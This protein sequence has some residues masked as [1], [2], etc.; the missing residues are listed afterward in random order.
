MNTQDL[1]SR[2]CRAAEDGMCV[3]P[4]K[5]SP[6]RS[7]PGKHTKTPRVEWKKY[8]T[9]D[10]EQVVKL[11][12]EGA[13]HFGID[14][15][16]SGIWVVDIDD[17]AS[18][19]R[20]P[21]RL[22]RVQGTISG[23][24]HYIYRRAGF[25]QRNTT[26]APTAGVDIRANGGFIVWYGIGDMVEDDIQPW[27][28]DE[29]ILQNGNKGGTKPTWEPRVVHE[30][31]RDNDLIS[32][33]GTFIRRYP[34]ATLDLVVPYAVGHSS[35]YHHP[36]LSRDECV[37]CATSSMRWRRED[38]TE[39]DIGYYGNFA[40]LPRKHPPAKICGEWLR[41]GSY[42]LCYARAGLGKTAFA[43]ELVYSIKNELEFF[44]E[45][46]I[47]PGEVL[48]INGD[49]PDWQVYERLGFLN[50]LADLW[51][52]EQIN[53]FP[54][55]DLLMERCAKYKLIILDN[56][57]ALFYLEDSNKAECWQP[58]NV[59]MRQL[60]NA[61]AAV[62]LMVHSGKGLETS[63]SFG[64]SAQEW[65]ADNIIEL[66]APMIKE[67]DEYKGAKVK[68]TRVVTWTKSRLCAPPPSRMFYFDENL[69]ESRLVCHWKNFVI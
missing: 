41:A 35:M 29:P 48:W 28:W 43:A 23:G 3:F 66:R 36:P 45:R 19:S 20:L 25:D 40:G 17:R 11:P 32:A 31:G 57:P 15:E 16:K 64:S 33:C 46:C 55:I 51:H 54:H 7:R 65:V 2:A 6:D 24:M 58:V 67:L 18:L 63:S 38:A 68:P 69:I 4:V 30:G 47:N 21:L 50:G 62:L 26:G 52:A 37:K 59:L 14:C 10:P 1:I 13:T 49:L 42:S 34:N 5:V 44:G 53:M 61:G 12:W 39:E 27:P 22:T 9:D 8:S 60:C 56:R